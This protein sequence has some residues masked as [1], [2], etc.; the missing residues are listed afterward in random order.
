[1]NRYSLIES[2]KRKSFE[3]N[4]SP[5]VKEKGRR[6]HKKT[7]RKTLPLTY[8]VGTTHPSYLP[9]LPACSYPSPLEAPYKILPLFLRTRKN[10][11][12]AKNLYKTHPSDPNP[13]PPRAT[14]VTASRWNARNPSRLLDCPATPPELHLLT[15]STLI[16]N[17]V[18]NN[19]QFRVIYKN[20]RK[21]KE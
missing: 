9:F 18:K 19:H 17:R 20:K 21:Q 2:F 13:H 11:N 15:R 4:V 12:S 8:P 16:G 14:P 1:M 7:R 6:V 3:I 5:V 10:E